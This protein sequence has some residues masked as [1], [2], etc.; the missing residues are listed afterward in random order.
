MSKLRAYAR[1]GWPKV[2]LSLDKKLVHNVE[3]AELND[4]CQTY[5][6]GAFKSTMAMF[7][8]VGYRYQGES[9]FVFENPADATLFT[10]KWS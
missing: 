9:I 2:S 10:L 7:G 1:K 4:W 5:C 3:H 6:V 8:K